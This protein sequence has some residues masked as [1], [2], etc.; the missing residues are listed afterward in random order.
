MGQSSW[1]DQKIAAAIVTF[2]P[3][4]SLLKRVIGALH[5]QVVKLYVVDNCSDNK[6]E[7]KNICTIK[8]VY[9][10]PLPE[11]KGIAAALNCAFKK[12]DD[13]GMK[14]LLTCDQDSVI[15][16]DFLEKIAKQK[17]DLI[18]QKNIGII[19]PN[20]VNRSTGE[21]EYEGETLK[22]ID[23]CITSGSLT[24]ISSWKE[25]QGFDEDMFID[26]V[27][28]DFCIRL[29]NAEYKILL[30]P[31]ICIEHEIGNAREHSLFGH[32]FLVL[33]HSAFRK[34]YIAQNILYLN[35]KFNNGQI[36]LRT[37]LRLCKQFVL[38]IF[39]EQDK[40]AKIKALWRGCMK[41]RFMCRSLRRF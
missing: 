4:I 37:I 33:N 3:D 30:L 6:T 32:K 7:I 21:K 26:G 8:D 40:K 41:G 38:V 27:D 14:W 2:N 22:L 31:N 29:K 17:K 10:I 18:K 35:G 25:I 24:R 9:F 5:K 16:D 11:N 23:K 12:A 13:D 36:T 19:C 28:F 20:F 15:P 34:E 39:Y 1:T